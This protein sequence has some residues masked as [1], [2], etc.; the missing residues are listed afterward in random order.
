[1]AKMTPI[2]WMSGKKKDRTNS[3][4][5]E[6]L[7]LT[8]SFQASPSANEQQEGESLALSLAKTDHDRPIK[9]LD[10]S[11][12]N[13]G[14]IASSKPSSF[15]AKTHESLSHQSPTVG[16]QEGADEQSE[17]GSMNTDYLW[18]LLEVAADEDKTQEK[19]IPMQIVYGKRTPTAASPPTPAT[20]MIRKSAR[21]R[22]RLAR[23]A[24]EIPRN[25]RLQKISSA[26]VP[27]DTCINQNFK[28]SKASVMYTS[29]SSSVSS[30]SSYPTRKKMKETTGR[31]ASLKSPDVPSSSHSQMS[32]GHL[33]PDSTTNRTEVRGNTIIEQI[34]NSKFEHHPELAA[35]DLEATTGDGNESEKE[36]D[37][38]T[39]SELLRPQ[40]FGKLTASTTPFSAVFFPSWESSSTSTLVKNS[41]PSFDDSDTQDCASIGKTNIQANTPKVETV[42]TVANPSTFNVSQSDLVGPDS[43]QMKTL[44]RILIY[45]EETFHDDELNANL[46]MVVDECTFR[47]MT[48]DE[49]KFH[50]LPGA[51]FEHALEFMD[52]SM[53]RQAFVEVK[54]FHHPRLLELDL[55]PPESD[56]DKTVPKILVEADMKPDAEQEE[57]FPKTLVQANMNPDT[58]RTASNILQ[59]AIG[60]GYYLARYQPL[61][62]GKRVYDIRQLTKDAA[63]TVLH[64]SSN[65]IERFWKILCAAH[66]K[67]TLNH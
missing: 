61:Q 54:N 18:H 17:P 47:H 4:I 19:P 25:K 5:I 23:A 62:S 14:N 59:T 43:E 13:T 24:E 31:A 55:L 6:S 20:T 33:Y 10:Q 29:H 46:Q 60:Y 21:K 40:V 34:E 37:C 49:S 66:E 26:V 3:S 56:D 22:T 58:K 42:F 64:M 45:I 53:F 67:E 7:L 30:S 2:V 12:T 1:M 50:N 44:Q 16:G 9:E 8:S 11:A 51:I 63:D 38:G 36:M 28:R 52:A 65:D 27:T 39:N 15:C 35:Y 48:M 41:F 57:P 32:T